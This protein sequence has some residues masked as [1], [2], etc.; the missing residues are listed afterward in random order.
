MLMGLEF[1]AAHTMALHAGDGGDDHQHSTALACGG[2]HAFLMSLP[3]T[4]ECHYIELSA[5]LL[6]TAVDM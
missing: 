5:L 6:N 4:A 3:Q 1:W 2:Q